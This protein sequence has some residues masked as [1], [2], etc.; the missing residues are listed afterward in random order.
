MHGLPVFNSSL[1]VCHGPLQKDLFVPQVRNMSQPVLSFAVSSRIVI[2][3]S[4]FLFAFL[5]FV[6][7]PT[8]SLVLGL[9][10]R[11]LHTLNNPSD[12]ELQVQ[13]LSSRVATVLGQNQMSVGLD[14][15]P[16]SMY[17]ALL[18]LL[19]RH[20]SLCYL[21]SSAF[22]RGHRAGPYSE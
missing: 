21:C 14:L 13:P 17:S 19:I 4:L 2:S 12:T 22:P 7:F 9:E 18:L 20:L 5:L 11:A 15:S 10:P 1:P 8:S 3:S 16:Y 6:L